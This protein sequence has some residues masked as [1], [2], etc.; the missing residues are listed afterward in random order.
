MSDKSIATTGNRC[1]QYVTARQ[2]F[3]NSNRQ[4]YGRHERGLYVVY[5]YGEHW[6][7][8][9]YDGAQWLEN[10]DRTSLTTSKHRTQTHPHCHT[11][12]LSSKWMQRLAKG[13]YNAIAKERILTGEPA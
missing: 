9:I 13:G 2:A 11:V 8:F 10:S 12:L 5:S 3:H 4:L 7:L 6:P 1:R